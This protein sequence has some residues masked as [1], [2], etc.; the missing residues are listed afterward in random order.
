MGLLIHPREKHKWHTIE[1]Q[2]P[3]YGRSCD[4]CW[5]LEREHDK[6]VS[7]VANVKDLHIRPLSG[8]WHYADGSHAFRVSPE[9]GW[10]Y[11]K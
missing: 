8:Y 7:I 5:F 11:S 9:D 2:H 1:E 3:E 4:A 10:K 6:R